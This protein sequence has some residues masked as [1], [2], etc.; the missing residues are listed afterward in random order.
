MCFNAELYSLSISIVNNRNRMHETF[1]AP[2]MVSYDGH[3]N[4]DNSREDDPELKSLVK[5]A[6]PTGIHLGAGGYWASEQLQTNLHD[7]LL[8]P[9][10]T[11]LSL[12]AK[13]SILCDIARGLAYL[14][15][16][17]PAVIHCE[18]T[19]RNVLLNSD[20]VAKKSDFGN[21]RIIDI[22]PAC[23]S[24]FI[25][26][27]HVPGTSLPRPVQ[28]MPNST[29]SSISFHLNTWPSSLPLK[30]CLITCFQFMMMTSL[31]ITVKLGI[32]SIL[33]S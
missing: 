18:L 6:D 8:N 16:H 9:S 15:N 21:S 29:R 14:H 2:N 10:Y 25:S 1:I 31:F 26:T 24:E 33:I 32:R 11:N 17:K 30:C 27:S 4:C 28:I 12:I 7:Y 19:A 3:F 20:R 23:S 13:V 22:D 5:K